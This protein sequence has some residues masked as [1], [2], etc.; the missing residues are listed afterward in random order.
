M[1]GMRHFP[2]SLTAGREMGTADR[3]LATCLRASVAHDTVAVHP[4][5]SNN[6]SG[7]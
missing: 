7:L 6:R 4:L 3:Q 5:Q 1:A 2:G